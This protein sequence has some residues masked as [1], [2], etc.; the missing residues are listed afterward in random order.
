MKPIKDAQCLTL[1]THTEE[2]HTMLNPSQHCLVACLSQP[3]V[4]ISL[5]LVGC[6]LVFSFSDDRCTD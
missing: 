2:Q 6:L 3:A 4:Q 1:N 5:I